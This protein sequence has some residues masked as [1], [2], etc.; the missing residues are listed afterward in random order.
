MCCGI[1]GCFYSI[2]LKLSHWSLILSLPQKPVQ[3]MVVIN[4]STP[5]LPQEVRQNI[6]NHLYDLKTVEVVCATQSFSIWINK[7]QKSVLKR[8]IDEENKLWKSW[9]TICWL[10]MKFKLH[11]YR[12][13][14][15]DWQI[16]AYKPIILN[17]FL[18]L[19]V[20]GLVLT[21]LNKVAKVN[22]P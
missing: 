2:I 6:E 18:F 16:S 13:V 19:F 8:C 10:N 21:I 12:Y 5:A 22:L 9:T 3:S 20:F 7:C 11:V 4:I 14:I 15:Y 1:E 17:W